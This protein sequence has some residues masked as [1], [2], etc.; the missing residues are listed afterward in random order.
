MDGTFTKPA[1]KA[2]PAK[3]TSAAASAPT[4]ADALTFPLAATER[5][6]GKRWVFRCSKKVKGG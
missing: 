3:P 1:S 2:A 6:T 5:G 4:E